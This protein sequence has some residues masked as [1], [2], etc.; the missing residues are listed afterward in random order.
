MRIAKTGAVVNQA[1]A[2]A[3]LACP[4]TRASGAA[5]PAAERRAMTS[6]APPSEIDDEVAAVTVPPSRNAGLRSGIFSGFAR[7][8]ASSSASPPVAT[9]S[10]ANAPEAIAALARSSDSSAYSSCAAR[11]NW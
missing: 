9:S 1:G 3:W 8:G 5:S 2:C 7:P 6:A 10:A 11:V 4:T